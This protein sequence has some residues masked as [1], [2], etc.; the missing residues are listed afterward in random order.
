MVVEV[1]TDNHPVDKVH[2]LVEVVE[3]EQLHKLLMEVMELL[4]EVVAVVAV[5]DQIHQTDLVEM[6][7][8]E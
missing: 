6:V 7:V 2:L 8:Q 3:Q 4:I 1:L 5:E